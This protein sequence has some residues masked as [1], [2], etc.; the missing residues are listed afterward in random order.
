M[1]EAF[2]LAVGTWRRGRRSRVRDFGWATS[3]RTA[4]TWR[5]WHRVLSPQP[6]A[7][8]VVRVVVSTM[9]CSAVS[10]PFSLRVPRNGGHSQ[11][12]GRER[13]RKHQ[14]RSLA[15]RTNSIFT[16][17]ADLCHCGNFR[18]KQDVRNL[19][20]TSRRRLPYGNRE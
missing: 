7:A 3:R 8:G 4:G 2:L 11:K 10:M 15:H 6:T 9:S 19:G 17:V 18:M 14:D 16:H 12:S 5:R 1:P 13:H 20:D